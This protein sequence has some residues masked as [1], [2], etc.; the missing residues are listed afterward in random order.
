M[1][2]NIRLIAVLVVLRNTLAGDNLAMLSG[3]LKT[4]QKTACDFDKIQLTCPRGTSITIEIAQY[5]K[6]SPDSKEYTICPLQRLNK[7]N[8]GSIED[9]SYHSCQVPETHKYSLLQ[10]AIETC[11]KKTMCQFVAAPKSLEGNPCPDVRRLIYF[12]YKC[13]PYE[14]RSKVA[15]ENEIIQLTCSP[16]WRITIYSASYGRTEYESVQCAQPLG[17]LEETCL[18][19][20][21]NER[22]MQICHGKR[23][24]I[25]SAD[26]A[27]FGNPCKPE[28]RMY[29]KIVYTCV[30]KQILKDIY[31]QT[32]EQDEPAIYASTE[33]N[34]I[35]HEDQFFRESEAIPPAPKLHG[36]LANVKTFNA[37]IGQ[38]VEYNQASFDD[39]LFEDP[40]GLFNI[41]IV[42]TAIVLI[43]MILIVLVIGRIVLMKRRSAADTKSRDCPADLTMEVKERRTD[44][45]ISMDSDLNSADHV[46]MSNIPRDEKLFGS[47]Y[48]P[49]SYA[50]LDPDNISFTVIPTTSIYPCQS[51]ASDFT[52]NLCLTSTFQS[53]HHPV[54]LNHQFVATVLPSH[55]PYL[56]NDQSINLKQKNAIFN[57][58]Y[59]G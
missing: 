10:T 53:G 44:D 11:Q 56:Y 59:P 27:T 50:N 49:S 19:S 5:K 13:R 40:S 33:T 55:S 9:G 25:I 29:L 4:Y 2:N 54:Q 48:I 42:L 46:T 17:V 45:V 8:D 43:L 15:C 38:G 30:P 35:Y 7:S 23:R 26:T 58:F 34:E 37:T 39:T 22:V 1:D 51:S 12:A 28:S 6:P 36:G 24:C 47:T 52:N 16:Y 20:Y 57:E 21:A 14:F 31:D 32:A 18:A 41:Y 3:T